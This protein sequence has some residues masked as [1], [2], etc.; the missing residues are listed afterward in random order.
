M[1]IGD[2]YLQ[3]IKQYFDTVLF[4]PC[5]MEQGRVKSDS[6]LFQ[7]TGPEQPRVKIRSPLTLHWEQIGIETPVTYDLISIDIRF[8]LNW[9]MIGS[10]FEHRQWIG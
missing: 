6:E 3:T 1:S 5:Y 8:D 4:W 2:K 7:Y 10:Q 9:H